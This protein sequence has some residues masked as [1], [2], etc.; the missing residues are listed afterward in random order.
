MSGRCYWDGQGWTD[1]GGNDD[2]VPD[3]TFFHP[4]T[5]V[6]FRRLVLAI[7]RYKRRQFCRLLEPNQNVLIVSRV[8]EVPPSFV[9]RIEQLEA[10]V[11]VLVTEGVPGPVTDA[12]C[13][14]RKRGDVNACQ[15]R[16]LA[17]AT[18]LGLG[19]RSRCPES[20]SH[21]L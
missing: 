14:E 16:E 1:L 6:L 18:E 10:R 5:D 2:L 3:P 17:V 21:C 13:T 7:T 15:R 20:E 9:E 11:L 12:H 19:F 4:F 8:D